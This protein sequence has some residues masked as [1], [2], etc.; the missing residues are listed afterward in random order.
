MSQIRCIYQGAAPDFPATDQHPDARRYGPHT[1]PDGSVV[2]I[3]AVGG[4]PTGDEIDALLNP[5]A[6]TETAAQKLAATGLTVSDLK[7]L[8]NL[9]T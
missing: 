7:A 2:F 1:L 3:D 9:P 4:A 8:L 5:P 6:L